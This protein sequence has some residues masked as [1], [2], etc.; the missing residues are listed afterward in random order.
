MKKQIKIKLLNPDLEI[1]EIEY[2]DWIDLRAGKT[3]YYKD[4][5]AFVKGQNLHQNDDGS[6]VDKGRRERKVEIDDEKDEWE[7]Q[8]ALRG[9]KQSPGSVPLFII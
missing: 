2:G 4:G 1:K 5:E 3:M 7:K 9:T 8:H 6:G